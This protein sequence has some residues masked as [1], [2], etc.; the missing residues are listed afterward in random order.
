MTENIIGVRI[1]S[2]GYEVTFANIGLPPMNM[3]QAKETTYRLTNERAKLE[4]YS[5]TVDAEG[6]LVFNKLTD[7]RG[8]AGVGAF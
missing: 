6:Y 7:A 8:G 2:M 4:R 3:A 1:P 5:T